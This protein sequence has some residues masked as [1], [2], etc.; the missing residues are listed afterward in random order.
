M[1]CGDDVRECGCCESCA[2]EPCCYEQ[3]KEFVRE[4][5]ELETVR[6]ELKDFTQYYDAWWQMLFDTYPHIFIVGEVINFP[7]QELNDLKT[8]W[9]SLHEMTKFLAID[10]AKGNVMREVVQ[11]LEEFYADPELTPAPLIEPQKKLELMEK[12]IDKKI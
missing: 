9:R 8:W 4:Q 11:L 1:A 3:E 7:E 6:A 12:I 5:Q 2:R 10:L